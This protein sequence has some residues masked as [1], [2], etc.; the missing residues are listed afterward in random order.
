[1]TT[2]LAGGA[3]CSS[4]NRNGEQRQRRLNQKAEYIR[5]GSGEHLLSSEKP[6]VRP[7]EPYP[8]EHGVTA[9]HSK[10]TKEYF[11]CK[12]SS[13]NP[14]VIVQEDGREPERYRDCD[15]K[16]SLP[17]KDGKEYCYPILTDLLNA[18]QV[19][20]GQKV[21]I[22]SGHRCPE[23]NG[24]ADRSASNKSSKHMIGAEV[25]FY[26]QGMED[27]AEGVVQKIIDYYRERPEYAGDESCRTFE[28]YTK[29]DAHVTTLP[30]FNK[31]IFVKL[32]KR[33][34]GRDFDNRHPYPYI[35]VQV[36]YDRGRDERVIYSWEQASRGYL[37]TR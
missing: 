8:W 13:M 12:G 26:V 30:W 34:E 15:G 21:V 14:P 5:R 20:T 3:G 29:G 7:R 27:N 35:S 1:M 9:N 16:H 4:G 31:E 18:I 10:I 19:K 24:Y 37:R 25:D 32:F 2:L 6:R 11:R 17:L 23:H 36:R 22:T 33:N 28:R